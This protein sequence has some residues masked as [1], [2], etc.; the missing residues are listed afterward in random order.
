M[1]GD[2]FENKSSIIIYTLF[3]DTG[4][5]YRNSGP[6]WEPGA[7]GGYLMLGLI[8]NFIKTNSF[9]NKKTVIILIALVSTTSTTAYIAL[10]FFLFFI[11]YRTKL[12]LIYKFLLLIIVVSAS[13]YLYLNVDFLSQK[14]QSQLQS[15]EA[16]SISSNTN[17]QRFL[18]TLRDIQ[19]IRNHFFWGRGP[20]PKTRYNVSNSSDIRTNGFSDYWVRYGSVF[21][22]LSLFYLYQSFKGICC[23][24]DSKFAIF[25][26][27]IILIILQ[28]ETY[29]NYPLF[30]G[31]F[32]LNNVYSCQKKYDAKHIKPIV[33]F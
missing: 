9:F 13:G 32:F 10:F 26:L 20:N 28:S 21:F 22:V 15:A 3:R 1:A 6:F 11:A 18:S 14:V 7:F 4:G 33:S 17:S 30:W 27:I 25:S 29:F 19:D 23:Y 31:L 16:S 5:F 12:K 2:Y 24:F 8:F